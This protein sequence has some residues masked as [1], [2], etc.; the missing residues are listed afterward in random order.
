VLQFRRI[1]AICGTVLLAGCFMAQ[2]VPI[3]QG[4]LL[5]Q[6]AVEQLRLGMSKNQVRFLIGAP[7]L[8]E[9]FNQTEWNYVYRP[10]S[11]DD[12]FEQRTLILRFKDDVLTGIEGDLAAPTTTDNDPD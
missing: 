12:K 5:E 3:D 6:A 8:K 10:R 1:V 11:N 7:I 4:N 9:P 2:K